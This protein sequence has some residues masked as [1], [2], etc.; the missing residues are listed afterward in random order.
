MPRLAWTTLLLIA[1]A[2]CAPAANV[3]LIAGKPSHG[4]GAH[5]HN[6]GILLLEK[7]LRQN[8]GVET[9]VVRNNWP[10]DEKVFEGAHTLVFYMD[11]G[12]G[13][14]LIQGDRL[15]AIG[16]LMSKGVGLVLLHYAVEVPKDKGGAELLQWIGGYY[17]RPYSQN[18]INECE[19]AQASPRHPI[20]RGWKSFTGKDEYYY[21]IRFRENDPRVTPIL[22]AMLPREAPNREVIAWATQR[23]DGG[24]G[25][26]FTGGH[27]HTNWGWTDFRR[28]VLNAIL[29]TARLDVPRGGARCDIS[30]E[31]LKANLDVKPAPQ[32]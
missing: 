19:A 21:R 22:T 2:C 7:C 5:E 10:E 3:L 31:D 15:A 6:A 24:R 8:K 30:P 1:S 18:P 32:R 26:G 9:M 13:N 12:G 27:F 20:S 25:F 29:W 4:P 11:G 14:P 16:R 28:M 23:E 17:E